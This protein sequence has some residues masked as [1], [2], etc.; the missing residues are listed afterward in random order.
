MDTWL[1]GILSSGT[2]GAPTERFGCGCNEDQLF[3][4]QT[5]VQQ[6]VLEAIFLVIIQCCPQIFRHFQKAQLIATV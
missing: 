1:R 2:A 4:T 5:T 6:G 3:I